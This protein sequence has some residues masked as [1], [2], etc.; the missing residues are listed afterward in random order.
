[1][2]RRHRPALGGAAGVEHIHVVAETVL[3]AQ[4]GALGHRHV[5]VGEHRQHAVADQLQHLAA[6]IV[7]GVDRGLRIIVEERDDL[8][9]LDAFADR[10]RAAQIGEPQHGGDALGHAARDLAAQHLL[11]RVVAEI[12]PPQRPGDIGLRGGS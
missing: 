5:L 10:G 1:M 4:R 3:G 8:A 6:G 7:N 2:R 11:G 9:G 12:D